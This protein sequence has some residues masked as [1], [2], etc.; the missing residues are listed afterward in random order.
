VAARIGRGVAVVL[1][2]SGVFFDLWLSIIGVFVYIGAS[3]EEAA[4]IVHV[5]L[6][7]QR[8][9]DAM[10]LHPVTVAPTTSSAR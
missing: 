1:I 3:A 7:G 4:T 6:D 9:S 5:R 2:V 8:V 10:L